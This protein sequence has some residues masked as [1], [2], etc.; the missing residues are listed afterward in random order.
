MPTPGRLQRFAGWVQL[1]TCK[2]ALKSELLLINQ[3]LFIVIITAIRISTNWSKIIY[4]NNNNNFAMLCTIDAILNEG[5][6]EARWETPAK[7]KCQ[8]LQFCKRFFI[9]PHSSTTVLDANIQEVTIL[10]ICHNYHSSLYCSG[11]SRVLNWTCAVHEWADPLVITGYGDWLGNACVPG[12][13]ADSFNI[14]QRARNTCP[15]PST[16]CPSAPTRV[17]LDVPVCSITVSWGYYRRTD[18]N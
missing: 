16:A 4:S 11:L 18:G 14:T 8:I 2:P 1:P 10:R 3:K 13:N 17:T 6:N 15:L 7:T 9:Q 5:L 12:V